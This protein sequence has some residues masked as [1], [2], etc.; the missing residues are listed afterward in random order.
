M[1][2]MRTLHNFT[3]LQIGKKMNLISNSSKAIPNNAPN[4]HT[5]NQGWQDPYK[6]QQADTRTPPDSK[7]PK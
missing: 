6:V 7:N 5:G 1:T 4:P 3:R 2:P